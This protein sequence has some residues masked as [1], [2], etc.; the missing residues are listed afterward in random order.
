MF[1]KR[2][3]CFQYNSNETGCFNTLIY[4]LRDTDTMFY[5]IQTSSINLLMKPDIIILIQEI[6]RRGV[7][8]DS[9]CY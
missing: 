8:K 9:T 4:K 1:G 2:S 3:R 6:Y 7:L 5:K